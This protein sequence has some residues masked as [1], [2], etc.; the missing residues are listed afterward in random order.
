MQLVQYSLVVYVKNYQL[1]YV[2]TYSSSS[3]SS[4]Y[5]LKEAETPADSSKGFFLLKKINAD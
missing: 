5:D 1:C 2:I 4:H 3:N